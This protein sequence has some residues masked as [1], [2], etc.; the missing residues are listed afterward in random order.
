M[1]LVQIIRTFDC[2]YRNKASICSRLIVSSNIKT[3]FLYFQWK[4]IFCLMISMLDSFPKM[5]RHNTQ[6]FEHSINKLK[7]YSGSNY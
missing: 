2:F 1:L 4:V 5:A 6:I 3:V 7:R